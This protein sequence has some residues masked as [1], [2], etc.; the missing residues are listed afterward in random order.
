MTNDSKKKFNWRAFVSVLTAISCIGMTFSGVI[1]FVVPP[2]R[3]ANWSGWTLML[4]TKHQ[5]S[6]L[7]LWFSLIFVVVAIW[8]L[9]LNWKPFINYFKDKASRTFALRLEWTAAVILCAGV[10]IATLADIRPFSSL[11]D[12]NEAIK[13][14][15]DEP[16]RQGPV[17][18][19]ELMTLS[20]LAGYA[21]DVDVDAMLENLAAQGIEAASGDD[22]VGEIAEQH[23]ITPQQLYDIAVGRQASR[24]GRRGG[25]RGLG[26]SDNSEGQS[27]YMN[28]P[29]RPRFGQMT[30]RR[31]CEQM[32]M[33]ETRALQNLQDAGFGA[34]A[35]TTL[36][37]IA[38]T[39]G[40]HPSQIR[41]IIER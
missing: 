20:E 41:R 8:H 30:I 16:A 21:R 29:A 5:W 11:S 22:V 4:L 23:N 17:P 18:H 10:L 24:G 35:D 34:S 32:G 3:I 19:A 7:H 25:R 37:E 38:D 39:A 9:L 14:S 26:G 12:W 33:N 36:R 27:G 15:W 13:F 6:A 40:V 28:E 2:G 1:L 31:Y